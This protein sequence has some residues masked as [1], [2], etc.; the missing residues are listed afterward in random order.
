MVIAMVKLS[1]TPIATAVE[2]NL[3]RYCNICM[4]IKFLILLCSECIMKN[5]S[6]GSLE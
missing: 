5:I 1:K 2:N 6:L 3:M 4:K